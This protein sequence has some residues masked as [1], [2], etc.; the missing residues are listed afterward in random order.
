MSDPNDITP[1]LPRPPVP[2]ARYADELERVE[3]ELGAGARRAEILDGLVSRGLS[4][5]EAAHVHGLAVYRRLQALNRASSEAA[6]RRANQER[7]SRDL[8]A[9][10]RQVAQNMASYARR[11]YGQ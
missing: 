4:K 3:R 11:R 2:A 6:Y 1:P 5:I 10:E 8:T 9:D 7:R